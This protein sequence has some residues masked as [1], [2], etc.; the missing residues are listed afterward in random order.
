M[1]TWI[2][3]R[4]ENMHDCSAYGR[5]PTECCW[6]NDKKSPSSVS[7]DSQIEVLTTLRRLSAEAKLSGWIKG[8]GGWL[9]PYCS[10]LPKRDGFAHECL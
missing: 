1:A 8:G 4:C 6:S 9:C 2:E 3:I 7:D 5:N 10:K